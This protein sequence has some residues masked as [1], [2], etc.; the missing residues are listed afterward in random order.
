MLNEDFRDILSIFIEEKVEFI[1]VGAYALAVHGLPRAT[2]DI[3]L[4]VRPES[5]NSIKV[6]N[7]L[8]IF[9]A[10]M[11]GISAGDFCSDDLIFQIGLPPRR[12]DIITAISGLSFDEVYSDRVYAD[13]D[14]M[15]IPV[16]SSGNLIKNKLASARDKDLLDVK[17]LKKHLNIK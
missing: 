10:P 12:I 3:D 17:I 1:L 2:G 5:N 6:Y 13:V 14:G 11:S 4:L 7:A 16:I 15:S 9:G 8:Q